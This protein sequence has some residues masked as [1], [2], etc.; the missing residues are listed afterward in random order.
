MQ[1][2]T[3]TNNAMFAPL[4]GLAVLLGADYREVFL[5]CPLDHARETLRSAFAYPFEMKRGFWQVAE[6]YLGTVH[7]DEVQLEVTLKYSRGPMSYAVNGRLC[8]ASGGTRLCLQVRD[9]SPKGIIVAALFGY[10]SCGIFSLVAGLG[11]LHLLLVL[12]T[13]GTGIT[14]LVGIFACFMGQLHRDVVTNRT[15]ETIRQIFSLPPQ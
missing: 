13:V 15:V 1:L 9:R 12:L 10:G 5:P 6:E 8:G 7:G 3:E 11:W 4:T 14:V 2:T